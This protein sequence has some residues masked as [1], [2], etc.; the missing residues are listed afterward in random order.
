MLCGGNEVFFDATNPEARKFVWD[1]IKRI[2]GKREQLFWLDVA[3]P[4]IPRISLTI[5]V[6]YVD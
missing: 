3:E 1:K 4:N 2:I 5:T 6:Y